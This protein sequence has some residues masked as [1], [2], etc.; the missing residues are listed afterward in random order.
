M[1]Q[2]VISNKISTKNVHK[3]QIMKYFQLL[4]ESLKK[5]SSL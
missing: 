5:T 3:A 4:T 2:T 1:L